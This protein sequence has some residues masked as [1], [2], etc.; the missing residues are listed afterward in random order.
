VGG[1][2]HPWAARAVAWGPKEGRLLFE[3][4]SKNVYLAVAEQ[5]DKSFLV[6]FFKKEPLPV[7]FKNSA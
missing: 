3:K 6:L 2:G 5:T 4:R 1:R 7:S